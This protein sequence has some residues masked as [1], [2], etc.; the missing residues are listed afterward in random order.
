MADLR[1][2]GAWAHASR[3]VAIG[4]V[5]ALCARWARSGDDLNPVTFREVPSHP[6]VGL[7]AGGE[8][9]ATL[10][11]MVDR[12]K[13]SRTMNQAIRWLHQFIQQATGAK[14]P[15]VQPKDGVIP[16]IEGPAIVIGDCEEAAANGL[17]GK[18]L[19]VEGFA[20]K[21]A[22]DRV[23]IVGHDGAVDK[24]T[25]TVSSGTAWGMFEF[26]ERFVGVRW[27]YPVCKDHNPDNVGLSIPKKGTLAISPV[28]LE[29]APAFRKRAMWIVSMLFNRGGN[30]W[31]IAVRVHTPHWGGVKE[32]KENRPEVFQLR[33]DGTRS[34][35]ML[36]YGNPKTLETYLENIALHF[37]E[38]QKAHLGIHGDAITV[39]PN[40]A[41][42][43]CYCTDCRKLWDKD[44]GRYGTAS[45]I[46]ATFVDKL[47][48]EV[49]KRWPDKTI[50]FLPYLNY[51]AAPKGFKFPDNVEVQICGMPGLAQHKEPAIDQSEQANIDAWIEISGRKIQNW[52][53][54]CWPEDKTRA[55]YLFPHVIKEHYQK[56]RDKTVGSFINGPHHR[57]HWPRHHLSLYCW[58]KVLW[59]PEFDVDAGIEEY[60]RRMYGPAA[61]TMRELVQMQIDGWEKSRWPGGRLSPKG[62]YEYSYPR[63][64]VVHMEQL[65]AKA[66][67]EAKG[68]ELILKRIE[69]YAIPFAA[70]F[71]ESKDH[72]EG[73]GRTAVL[74]QKVGENPVVDGKLDD[75]AWQHAEEVSFI[76]ALDK[77]RKEPFYPTTLKAVWTFK[78]LTLGFRLSEPWPELLKRNVKGRDDSLVWWNDNVE[79]LLDVTGQQVGEF[80]HFIVTP[81]G[82]EALYD[83]KSTDGGWTSKG[84]KAR[85]HVGK[86]FWSLEVYLPYSTFTDA[87][88]PGPGTN[89]VWY[90]NF[91]RHRV[92]DCTPGRKPV[93]KGSRREYQRLNTTYLGPSKNLADFGPIR[94]ME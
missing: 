34:F 20:I 5:L 4:S 58:L 15:V 42:I 78:G 88:K 65:L 19:P 54:S 26:L 49:K 14:L 36:C 50:I 7:V 10:A 69:Y 35:S 75:A 66:R 92:C 63:E 93:Q 80:Y 28:W 61:A 11:I 67:Q 16:K 94:F 83:A 74:A 81:N 55:V 72:A 56:N 32:Y 25:R 57:H 51:T 53:Y 91:T 22:K 85:S 17:V 46:L 23:F 48:R 71:E 18:D 1:R 33:S 73:T 3:V 89:T 87:A 27:Y 86:D 45:R 43:A 62:I 21:T 30:S 70:F 68:D 41:H 29:D 82:T 8:P 31:P 59:D 38:G 47:A 60:C 24:R 52:H 64:D 9:K 13:R 40:D 2:K 39:S 79:L 77:K 76:R 84:V 6:P 12:T 37:D 90:G 44:G